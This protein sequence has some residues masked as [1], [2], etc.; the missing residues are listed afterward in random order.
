MRA[1][2][3]TG[4]PA[5]TMGLAADKARLPGHEA[6]PGG[7]ATPCRRLTTSTSE[8]APKRVVIGRKNW[9]FAANAA[10]ENH[11]R[12]SSLVASCKRHAIDPQRYLTSVLAKIGVTPAAEL[13]Q[14]LPDV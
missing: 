2:N 7:S 1:S 3:T 5:R 11:A 13:A 12:L 10:A 4:P 14:F 8:R 9:L 6:P